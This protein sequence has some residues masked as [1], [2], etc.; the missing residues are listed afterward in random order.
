MRWWRWCVIRWPK[1]RFPPNTGAPVRQ[2][3]ARNPPGRTVRARAKRQSVENE[4]CP[5][6]AQRPRRPPAAGTFR[7]RHHRGFIVPC[8]RRRS[9]EISRGSLRREKFASD[10]PPAA[11]SRRPRP[12]SLAAA[13]GS[14]V[15]LGWEWKSSP[16][17]LRR[18]FKSE[19]FAR[20]PRPRRFPDPFVARLRKIC[21]PDSKSAPWSSTR[22]AA[23]RP[24]GWCRPGGRP[25]PSTR[26]MA[27]KSMMWRWSIKTPQSS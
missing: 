6:P 11:R 21:W 2:E 24:C 1:V 8:R 7:H 22:R 12:A 13:N 17:S 5:G 20:G 9:S 4:R 27:S 26:E 15:V 16:S 14:A 10:P 25:I 18:A 19:P 3:T 23:F